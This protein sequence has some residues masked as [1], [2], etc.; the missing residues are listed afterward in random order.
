M[1]LQAEHNT[2]SNNVRFAFMNQTRPNHRSLS[3]RHVIKIKHEPMPDSYG[4]LYIDFETKIIL[5]SIATLLN[6]SN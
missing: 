6:I 4:C 5:R 3:N 1:T 2:V